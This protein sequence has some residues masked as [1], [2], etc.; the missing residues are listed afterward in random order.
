MWVGN[1]GLVASIKVVWAPVKG[2]D[3]CSIGIHGMKVVV[4]GI[5]SGRKT[6]GWVVLW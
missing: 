6:E 3:D 1:G 5:D 4:C 2:G